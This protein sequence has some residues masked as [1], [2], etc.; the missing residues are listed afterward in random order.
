MTE[1]K[2]PGVSKTLCSG[3]GKYFKGVTVFDLHRRM[4]R[5]LSTDEMLMRGF[6]S[7]SMRVHMLREGKPH[8]E[9]HDVWYM[10]DKE[11]EAVAELAAATDEEL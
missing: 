2:L 4:R 3:C 6:A 9:I 8:D 1:Q 11:D 5:C 7:I 10:P